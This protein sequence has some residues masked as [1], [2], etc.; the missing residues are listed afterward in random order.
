MKKSRGKSPFPRIT[1][2]GRGDTVLRFPQET[3]V[4]ELFLVWLSLRWE[5]MFGRPRRGILIV[6]A[7][8]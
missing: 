4:S 7:G 8:N 3:A 2:C 6:T 5:R 1:I